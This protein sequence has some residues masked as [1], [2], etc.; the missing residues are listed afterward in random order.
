MRQHPPTCSQLLPNHNHHHCSPHDEPNK[1]RNPHRHPVVAPH[2]LLALLELYPRESPHL[3]EG[4]GFVAAVVISR[5]VEGSH[6]LH[7]EFTCVE[8]SRHFG[9]RGGVGL[10]ACVVLIVEELEVGFDDGVEDGGG[11]EET[12]SVVEEKLISSADFFGIRTDVLGE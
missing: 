9:R 7:A 12:S 11:G 6:S 8:E 4:Y 2:V 10:C 5:A 3:L 1:P